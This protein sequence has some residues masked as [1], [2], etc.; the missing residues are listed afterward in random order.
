MRFEPL[1]LFLIAKGR[2]GDDCYV[3]TRPPADAIVP[4]SCP[5]P[6]D[7]VVALEP[8]DNDERMNFGCNERYI[9]RL[10]CGRK[11]FVFSR[12][13][14]ATKDKV[15]SRQ[16]V[17][18]VGENVTT[19]A[20]FPSG[21]AENAAWTC[22]NGSLGV[23]A[24]VGYGKKRHAGIFH[25]NNLK[26][27][28]MVA[29]ANKS[30]S[31]CREKVSYMQKKYPERCA[32]DGKLAVALGGKFVYARE[33]KCLRGGRSL[34]VLVN[35]SFRSL[36][37][38]GVDPLRADNNVYYIVVTAFRDELFGVL[39]GVVQGEAGVFLTNSH[40]GIRWS[41]PELLVR[42]QILRAWRTPD[43]VVDDLR[44][45]NQGL[46]R[47]TVQHNAGVPVNREEERYA[48]SEAEKCVLVGAQCPRCYSEKRSR[49]CRYETRVQRPNVVV[50][51][52]FSGEL[53]FRDREHAAEVVEL[54]RGTR[55]YVVTYEKFRA[56]AKMFDDSKVLFVDEPVY[57]DRAIVAR[58]DTVVVA[59]S[60][61]RGL[62]S[63]LRDDEREEE[64]CMN[65]IKGVRVAVSYPGIIQWG[66]FDLALRR[67]SRYF[68]SRSSETSVVVRARTDIQMAN[69]FDGYTSL[70]PSPGHL[71]CHS[72]KFFYGLSDAVLEVFGDMRNAAMRDFCGHNKSQ[73]NHRFYSEPA[74]A[75]HVRR[76]NY[77]CERPAVGAVALYSD[78]RNFSWLLG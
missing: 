12:A 17:R 8:S 77:S 69:F 34:Q 57:V 71:Y 19:L 38:D 74:F 5:L 35:D 59:D 70:R 46:L 24:G 54:C 14:F 55:V 73:E 41:R 62:C 66:L 27:W 20:E 68:V 63:K 53:R 31:Q 28:R 13:D 37:I 44:V 60:W 7:G 56:A 10:R 33:N 25:S 47:F 50:H 48:R 78:R 11:D 4:D 29:S 15:T 49:L 42:S 6:A 18:V 30:S 16:I 40:D 39:P 64:R 52:I 9:Q 23:Y 32:F 36:E 1:I 72:D 43:H 76:K 2:K 75:E 65:S 26:E 67:W 22:E 45:T 51:T 21:G 3:A 58:K 61:F